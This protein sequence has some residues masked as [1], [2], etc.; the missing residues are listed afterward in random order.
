MTR[1]VLWNIEGEQRKHLADQL[2]LVKRLR[3]EVVRTRTFGAKSVEDS[4]KPLQHDDGHR[5]EL[6]LMTEQRCDI[7]AIHVGQIDIQQDEIGDGRSTLIQR[8]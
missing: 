1:H 8:V 7:I 5:A 6:A 3:N 4:I 2:R